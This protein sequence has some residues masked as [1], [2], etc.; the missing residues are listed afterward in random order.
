MKDTGNSAG[1][2]VKGASLLG[3]LKY[4]KTRS[5][6]EQDLEKVLS[7]L[8]S[9][10]EKIFRRKVIAVADYPYQA[11]VDLIRAA[12]SA[13]GSGDLSLCRELGAYAASRDVQAL[14]KVVKRE[15]RPQDLVAATD[16]LWK[17]YH[18]NSGEMKV[19]DSSPGHMVIAIRDFPE[20]DPAHCR[21]MEG[22]FSRAIK[23]IGAEWVE[24]IKEVKCTSRGDSCHEFAGRLRQ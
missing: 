23:E 4:I 8:P 21:L 18:M 6:G 17:S 9:A 12:D 10:S 5:Q 7:A 3:F 11:F 1:P 22:Y 20:M 14:L 13:L 24:E 2:L 15:P 16:L 19:E